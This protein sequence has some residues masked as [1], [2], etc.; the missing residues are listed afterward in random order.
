MRKIIVSTTLLI[1]IILAFGPYVMGLWFQKSYRDLISVYNAKDKLHLTLQNY[2][3][4]WF[5]SDAT[6]LI[7]LNPQN[8]LTIKQQIQHGP[9]IYSDFSL[10]L[11]AIQNKIQITP[12][13]ASLLLVAGISDIKNIKIESKSKVSFTG[14]YFNSI[15]IFG[16]SL[17]DNEEKWD[18][19]IDNIAI[20]VWIM[21][22]QKNFNGEIVLT[23]FVLKDEDS[24]FKLNLKTSFNNLFLPAV[25][26]VTDTIE[27]YLQNGEI[28]QGQLKQKIV[29]QIPKMI[30]AESFI[31]LASLDI[32]AASGS[33]QANGLANW[34]QHDLE[35][36]DDFRDLLMVTQAKLDVR[37][38]KKMLFD[39]IK[40]ASAFPDFIRD[41]AQPQRESLV[42]ARDQIEF[43]EHRNDIF[44]DF[45]SS[46]GYI[47]KQAEDTLVDSQ[48]KMVPLAVYTKTVKDLFL[49]RQIPLV[50]SYQL[51]WQY[52]QLIKPYEF[53]DAKIDEFQ[54]VAEKQIQEQFKK[55]LD[56]GYIS[57]SNGEYFAAV[58]WSST[59]FTS[60][61][62]EVK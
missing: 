9:L 4:G 18:G 21:P 51:V 16:L 6:L 38:S 45:L 56:K 13:I 53:L 2:H 5:S 11:A 39:M 49:E 42:A 1:I 54:Q 3:Q 59:M 44:I 40:T 31:K 20:N 60:N 61:G 48:N 30:R 26:D 33:M 24:I 15:K 10:G 52:A 46:N 47:S 57:E 17:S 32:S 62:R 28:Y 55:L 12:E 8:I 36:M 29:K 19:N 22:G 35:S 43:A 25:Y 34:S 7:E 58:K 50:V 14:N 27:D 37:I 41:V 23:H